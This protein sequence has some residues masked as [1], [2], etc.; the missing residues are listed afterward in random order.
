M[1]CD[2][3]HNT[4]RI[5]DEDLT[6]LGEQLCLA[7]EHIERSLNI[8]NRRLGKKPIAIPKIA[9]FTLGQATLE[10]SC[11][12]FLDLE[13]FDKR[14]DLYQHYALLPCQRVA[15]GRSV[16]FE[17]LSAEELDRDFVVIGKLIY[18]GLGLPK[19][20]MHC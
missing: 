2:Y 5:S 16:I 11:R 6:L 3:P 20:R 1:W 17:C 8:R 14:Q 18:E 13:Y 12:E 19:V 9:E 10:R 4:R 15:T 7:L